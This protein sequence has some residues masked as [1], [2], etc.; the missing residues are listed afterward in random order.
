MVFGRVMKK[1]KLYEII[2]IAFGA[3]LSAVAVALFVRPAQLVPAGIVGT[4]TLIKKEV[5]LITGF[6]LSF[7]LMYFLMN[8]FLLLFVIRKLGKRFVTLSLFHI[9]F[10]SI[11]VDWIPTFSITNDVLLLAIFGGVLN[12]IGI[13]ISLKMGGSSGGTD[14]IS[15][16][17]STVKN[18]PMWDKIMLFNFAL[19][20]YNGWRFGWTLS[21]YSIIYQ[22]TSTEILTTFHDRFK[23]SSLR[24]ITANPEEVSSAILKVMR[25]GITKFDG[26]GMY[27]SEPRSML[28]TVVNSFE[29]KDVLHAIKTT[30]PKAFIEV[31][32]VDRI[33]GNFRQ[34]PID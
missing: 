11:Y 21:F 33:E 24:I 9:L 5:A 22:F 8:I 6:N 34:K 27:S 23:L 20:I 25:H 13:A 18:R 29:I 10:T 31:S 30:D 12:G 32:E 16:Y 19:L 28:Y 17:F 1:I 14:F 7:G 3:L 26:L 15:I 4:V 2:G